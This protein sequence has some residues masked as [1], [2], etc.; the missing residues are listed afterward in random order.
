MISTAIDITRISRVVGYKIKNENFAPQTP[1]LPQKIVVLAES[2]AANQG[3]LD[4]TPFEFI[5]AA[6]VGEVV[7]YGSPAYMI[8]RILRPVSGNILG[9][10]PTKMYP[11]ASAGG[12]T[13]A[14]YKLGV[15]V[16]SSVTANATHKLIINGRDNI[17][18]K[19][20]AFN[21]AV[22]DN[23]AAVRASIIAAVNA[24][25]ASPVIAA[26][27]VNDVD[28]TSKW[29]GA[30]ALLDVSIDTGNVAAGI[31]YSEI[32]NT[33]GTGVVDLSTAL[34]LFGEEWNTLLIN[35][36]GADQITTLEA[37]NGVP[38]PVNPTG[39]YISTVFKPLVA[40]FGSLLSDKD[41]IVAITDATARKD[42]VTNVLCPA[43]NSK[44][45][46]FEAAA[47]MA[48]LWAPVAQNTP[49]ASIG[50]RSYNDMPVPSDGDIG[51]F[52]DY[53]ARDFMVKGGSSTVNLTSGKY[54]VQDF[55]TTYHPD[56]EPIPKFRNVRDLNIDFNMGYRWKLIMINDIQDKAVVANDVPVVVGNT[57]SPKQVKQ[58]AISHFEN[59][60]SEALIVDADFSIEN[61][62]VGINATNPARIDF[63]SRY[64]RSSTAN[65]VSSDVGVDFAFTI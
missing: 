62:Q 32:S 59:A 19:S 52:N 54:T 15:S 27:N 37:F 28:L 55:T 40:L 25:L 35:P 39:R 17:D 29:G 36:F 26:E 48:A 43:P 31:V 20:F 42:Q 61:I 30:T 50:G 5:N 13:Q 53:D 56:S 6:E 58:L 60:E 24:V 2:N 11:V 34:A 9:G 10:I 12:A 22:G 63:A 47:N 65:V 46:A 49:H 8:A 23:V 64:K 3:S 4:V 38:D 7:G 33:D 18:G 1:Y 14:V 51:D 21:V 41:D 45:F 16:A 57:V 44:G